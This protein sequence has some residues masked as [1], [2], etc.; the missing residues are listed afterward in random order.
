MYQRI[1]L[2]NTFDMT[3]PE[4]VTLIIALVPFR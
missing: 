4:H 1:P 3:G 2:G